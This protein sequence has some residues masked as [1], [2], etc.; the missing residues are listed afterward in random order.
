MPPTTFWP[1]VI[2]G[3]IG[4]EAGAPPGP[5]TAGLAGL[6]GTFPLVELELEAEELV[7]DA[8]VPREPSTALFP[9]RAPKKA[10][11]RPWRCIHTTNKAKLS[12]MTR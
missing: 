4:L 6:V 12:A 5:P 3:G 8:G 9:P 1:E 7:E 11:H 10:A 2:L